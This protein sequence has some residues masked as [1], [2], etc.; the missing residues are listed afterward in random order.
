M[1]PL[2]AA[3]FAPVADAEHRDLH[4]HLAGAAIQHRC[5]SAS[6]RFGAGLGRQAF[7]E[8]IVMA[9]NR[10]G[11]IP[12]DFPRSGETPQIVVVFLAQKAAGVGHIQLRGFDQPQ[13]VPRQLSAVIGIEVGHHPVI[14]EQAAPYPRLNPQIPLRQRCAA[15]AVVMGIPAEWLQAGDPG[16]LAFQLRRIHHLPLL[17]FPDRLDISELHDSFHRRCRLLRRPAGASTWITLGALGTHRACRAL[18][19]SRTRWTLRSLRALGA[20]HPGRALQSSGT[21]RSRLTLGALR[22]HHPRRPLQPGWQ[23]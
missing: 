12:P 9:D 6:S 17:S 8:Q 20:L 15:V 2:A 13:P 21:S 7:P 16:D 1:P 22:A 4:H 23:S 19:S 14:A 11:L 18:T 3:G 5:R 10:S